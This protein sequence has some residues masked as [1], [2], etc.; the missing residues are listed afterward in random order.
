MLSL[1]QKLLLGFGG[2]L[3]IT[4]IGGIQSI[5]QFRYLGQSIDVILK[6]NYRSVIACQD[7]KEALE[8]MDS[9][10][11]FTFLGYQ[12]EGTDLIRKNEA[13]FGKALDI[14]LH[15]ITI[16]GE[17]EKAADLKA[18]YAAYLESLHKVENQNLPINLR[19]QLYFQE[20]LPL[21]QKV[22][23]MAD[24]ILQMNQHNMHEANDLARKQAAKAQRNTVIFLFF[25]AAIAVAFMIF[26]GKWILNPI[27]RLIYSA[28]AIRD[29]NLDLVVQVDSRDEIGRLSEAFNDMAL[30]LRA[31]R[32][33][34]QAKLARTQE[35]AKETFRRLPDAV[36]IADL[37]GKIE[38]VTQS[39]KKFF[40]LKVGAFVQDAAVEHLSRLFHNIVHQDPLKH[41][42]EEKLFQLFVSGEERY[43]QANAAPMND[44]DGH[45]TGVILIMKDV[46]EQRRV[47]EMKRGLISTVSHELKTPLTSIRMAIHLL[48]EEKVGVLT[49]KQTELLLA[50]RED[51]DRLQQILHN[52]LD[53]SR[54]ESGRLRMDYQDIYAQSLVLDAV[55][56]IRRAAQDGGIE[57]KI[58]LAE[59]LPAVSADPTQ[60]GHVFSNLLSNAL[61]FTAPG[62]SIT[63]SA[64]PE[65]QLVRFSV[66][67]TG[68][69]IPHQFMQRIFE[70]FFRV[71]DQK[72]ATGAGLGLAIAKEIVEAHG[73]SINVV[74]QEGKG[75]TFSFTLKRA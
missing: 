66:T 63:V 44:R 38:I 18:L 75:T 9:G 27:N 72:S 12:Q 74:S 36:A 39:A 14:E 19:R 1:R 16:S 22:K 70:Q 42:E 47:D 2:L 20:L 28:E 73:G 49:E 65:E 62:G 5:I 41:L 4:L 32:R 30:S 33:S 57:L 10:I 26:V 40:G 58:Q 34:D 24:E 71:P 23:S 35:A 6:E 64:V 13:V 56:P 46:T 54:I 68:S 50:A 37:D 11:L 45:R 55:E 25:G 31:L 17:R 53:I 52:L 69:G 60:I 21:F 61:R 7:M 3:L 15:N 67:D 51:S 8:R 43:F 59:D 29:G 48:L